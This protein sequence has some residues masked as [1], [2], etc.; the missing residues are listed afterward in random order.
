MDTPSDG[1]SRPPSPPRSSPQRC[2]LTR[3]FSSRA[4]GAPGGCGDDVRVD[5]AGQHVNRLRDLR[6][7]LELLLLLQEVVIGLEMG[8]L[9]LAVLPDQDERR[10]ED[11]LEGD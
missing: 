8:E 4:S 10:E 1:V 7:D 9:R 2:R 3:Q 6:V 11:R 5:L